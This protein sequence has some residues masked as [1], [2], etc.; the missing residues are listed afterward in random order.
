MSKKPLIC[1]DWDGTLADSMDLCLAECRAALK[2][3][4]LPDLP[5]E[6]IATC[7]GPT[8]WDACAIL[9]V[10]DDWRTEFVRIRAAAGL[11]LTPTV[12]RLYPGIADML[13]ALAEK[14][15]LA[16][17]SNG[18]G[19]YIRLCVEVFGLQGLFVTTRAFT[20]GMT[21]ADLLRDVLTQVQ[22]ER[23]I[24]VGDRAGDILAGKACGLPTVAACYGCGNEAD[25]TQADVRCA[26]VAGL[27]RYLLGWAEDCKS[28][29]VQ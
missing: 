28:Y 5:D 2:A 27:Q 4:N 20:E 8:D 1:F 24:M 26:D 10:P 6:I 19:P 16:V 9:G 15:D 25:Y 14:A 23:A 12:N 11:E 13:R 21:K 18:Q 29:G 3:M 17:V 22:P 7:N